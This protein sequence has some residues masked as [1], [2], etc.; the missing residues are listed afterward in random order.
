M[1]AEWDW[2]AETEIPSKLGAHL[3]FLEEVLSRMES[4]GWGGRDLFG[5]Q[6]TLEETLTN[7]IRH[8]NHSDASKLVRAACKVN[9]ERFWLSVEDEGEGFCR[10]DVADCTADE[11]VG[12]FGGRGMALI[13]AYMADVSFNDRGNRITVT[14]HRGYRPPVDDAD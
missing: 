7:A 11:N 6:M 13:D 2:T 5:V 12:A 1:S 9:G 10:D 4:L 3:P 14:T 8:G